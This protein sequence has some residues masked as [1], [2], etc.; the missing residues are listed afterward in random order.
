MCNFT[1]LYL[2][3]DR[4]FAAMD[5]RSI[6]DRIYVLP[7]PSWERLAACLARVDLPKGHL[8]ME[9]G[10]VERN[11]FFL[12][13]GIARACFPTDGRNVTFWIG[14][15][16]STLLSMKGFTEGLPGYETIELME[17]SVLYRLHRD[18][19]HR[20]FATD[21]HIAN[22]GRRFAERELLQTEERLIPFLFTTASERY[23]KLLSEHPDLLQ[24]LPL[25]C[26]ASYIGVTP[27]SLSRIRG[28]LK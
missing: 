5:I 28:E 3:F 11:I 26:L 25:E 10:R 14:A 8:L 9:T 4:T 24:R 16:G 20:L 21:I 27:V 7:E 22:W 15:E 17:D 2:D 23:R 6:I 12:A 19:L 18:D 13:Q 1:Y